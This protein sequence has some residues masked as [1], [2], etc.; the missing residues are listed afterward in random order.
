MTMMT[1]DKAVDLLDEFLKT[2]SVHSVNSLIQ[3]M[4]GLCHNEWETKEDQQDFANIC[5]NFDK[6]CR[7]HKRSSFGRKQ[8]E[9]AWEQ[10]FQ[11][12]DSLELAVQM[13]FGK[14]EVEME[15]NINGTA[16]IPKP[17]YIIDRDGMARPI[18]NTIP[19]VIEDAL[20]EDPL[21]EDFSEVRKA[22]DTDNEW[23]PCYKAHVWNNRECIHCKVQNLEAEVRNLRNTLEQIRKSIEWV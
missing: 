7:V 19:D 13:M 8:F 23:E 22:V 21:P 10:N 9:A 6:Y 11:V 17:N 14:P 2:K 20:K 1:F 5:S 3:F 15:I 18:K 4:M 12:E 16:M